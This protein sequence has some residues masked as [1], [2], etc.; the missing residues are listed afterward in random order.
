MALLFPNVKF[1]RPARSAAPTPLRPLGPT[2]EEV[3]RSLLAQ[4]RPES[5]ARRMADG[6]LPM[7]EPS[8]LARSEAYSRGILHGSTH[9]NIL[10][11]DASI[12]NPQSDMGK[13]IYGSNT[14]ADVEA[15]YAG[16]G[17]DLTGRIDNEAEDISNSLVDMSE[18]EAEDFLSEHGF[19]YK[20]YEDNPYDTV[21]SIA[22]ERLKGES[23][24]V[25][26]P[27]FVD[28][29]N[30]AK[31]SGSGSSRTYLEGPDYLEMAR[32]DNPDV[33]DEDEL[34]ELADELR[35]NDPDG[36]YTRVF[37]A[38]NESAAYD[39]QAGINSVMGD[40][41]D[42][43]AEGHLD[44]TDLE[45]A[46]KTSLH[47]VYDDM[48]EHIGAGDVFRQVVNN[49]GYKGIID[50]GVNAKFGTGRQFGT[51]M[52]GVK[53]ST[54]HT[55]VSPDG[56]N[57]IRSIWAAFDPEY[58]GPN[59]LGAK[60]GPTGASQ[61]ADMFDDEDEPQFEKGGMQERIGRSFKDFVDDS[62][63]YY[64]QNGKDAP[65]VQLGN[66]PQGKP[67]AKYVDQHGF[68][69]SPEETMR[70]DQ[71]QAMAQDRLQSLVGDDTGKTRFDMLPLLRNDTGA[72]ADASMMLL[73][74]LIGREAAN[75]LRQQGYQ[76]GLPRG[77][78]D[79]LLSA[80]DLLNSKRSGGFKGTSVLDFIL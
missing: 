64:A 2:V 10:Q 50:R 73:S 18:W 33:T 46:I 57:T 58:T 7:D 21:H 36:L 42:Q 45:A 12:T 23:E 52:E 29:T 54:E 39:Y 11:F 75:N 31:I 27:L 19:T 77:V 5:V 79:M 37:D 17:P 40:L 59:I 16:V 28:P 22:T 63:L 8:R 70:Y 53:P 1:A 80:E 30:Y 34:Y 35:Y 13:G 25:T 14:P 32:R 51:G 69:L 47:D 61:A 65:P 24:G 44:L 66:F 62:R 41:T 74:P 43:I 15:N 20:D 38:L 4:G 71:A 49:L 72:P 9:P 78:L 60:G 26:Y 48:G 6:S 67:K 56:E 55:I 68:A 3:Y 76:F